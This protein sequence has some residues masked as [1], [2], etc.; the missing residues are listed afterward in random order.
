[1][2]HIFIW[3]TPDGIAPVWEYL[4]YPIQAWNPDI[5]IA[6]RIHMIEGMQNICQYNTVQYVVKR[7]NFVYRPAAVLLY[8][9]DDFRSGKG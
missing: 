2:N 7:E 3:R 8:C 4:T 5:Y 9:W 1:M 6:E